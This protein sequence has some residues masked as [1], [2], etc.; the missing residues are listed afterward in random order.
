MEEEKKQSI[1][2]EKK[3]KKEYVILLIIVIAIVLIDQISKILATNIGEINVI[4]GILKFNVT[5]NTNPAYGIGSDSTI[6]YVLTN[7]V[8]LGV[9]FKFIT[10]QNDF[11]DNKLKIFLSLI[12]AGGLANV[13]D[14]IFRGYV[15]EFIDFRQMINIPVFNIA[16]ICVLIGWIS[17][18]AIF[19]AFTVTEWRNGKEKKVI[20]QEKNNNE[21]D[22]K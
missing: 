20:K 18:A 2:K 9:I 6:M 16:D 14:R 12:F 7:I 1:K 13:I 15:V 3:I 22:K 17:V 4:N 5:E 19:A 10:T 21:K 11:V 8:I